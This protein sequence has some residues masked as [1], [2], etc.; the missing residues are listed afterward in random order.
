MDITEDEQQAINE[1]VADA[2]HRAKGLCMHV[3]EG[4]PHPGCAE[5][6]EP[7]RAPCPDK[8]TQIVVVHQRSPEGEFYDFV[9]YCAEH[10]REQE[11]NPPDEFSRFITSRPIDA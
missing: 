9:Q 6:A 5:F 10:A 3:W 1:G 7:D 2:I 4:Y 11:Y 8:A